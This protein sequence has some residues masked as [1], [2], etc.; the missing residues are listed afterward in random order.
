[1][2]D[3]V[4]LLSKTGYEAFVFKKTGE[5]TS[6]TLAFVELG[7]TVWIK[8]PNFQS[9]IL[10]NEYLY[11]DC[12][13]QVFEHFYIQKHNDSI[14]LS[15]DGSEVSDFERLDFN[16]DHLAW[17]TWETIVLSLRNKIINKTVNILAKRTS[18][19]LIIGK[20][21]VFIEINFSSTKFETTHRMV[22]NLI[23]FVSFLK[24]ISEVVCF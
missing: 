9:I 4:E 5:F 7:L 24:G 22:C 8:A 3:H 17:E 19:I 21:E 18:D 15:I 13:Q 11:E 16:A 14:I 23:S 6:E 10:Q 12:I 1:M 2:S 20:S